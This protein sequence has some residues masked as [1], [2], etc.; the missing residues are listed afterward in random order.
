MTELTI[1]RVFF[2]FLEQYVS[3]VTAVFSAIYIGAFVLSSAIGRLKL[4][5]LDFLVFAVFSAFLAKD[6]VFS[7]NLGATVAAYNKLFLCLIVLKMTTLTD[8]GFRRR[9]LYATFQA[10]LYLLAVFTLF[11]STQT[12][13]YTISWGISVFSLNFT[14]PHL[15][16]AFIVL[17]QALIVFDLNFNQGVHRLFKF[18]LALS[19]IYPL[20]MTGA[21]T[22]AAAGALLFLL[23]LAREVRR[24]NP[25]K[26]SIAIIVLGLTAATWGWALISQAAA[27]TKSE[28][29]S[30]AS[31]S[32]GRE[33][34][35]D[36]YLS[37]AF[38]V[39]PL[40][41]L[42]GLGTGFFGSDEAFFVGSHNDFLY[43]Q[44]AFG[45]VG[46]LL[47]FSYL[48]VRFWNSAAPF[49]SFV[50]LM[51]A[52][53]VAFMNGLSG[54]TDFVIALVVYLVSLTWVPHGVPG[55][56]SPRYIRPNLGIANQGGFDEQPLISTKSSRSN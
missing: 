1:L 40:E 22:F 9:W 54:Y 51:V 4:S 23:P 11:A 24:L 46:I 3:G 2:Q 38:S 31:I 45:A 55:K 19:L 28:L 32:N 47:F 41:F 56:Y 33:T 42:A 18:L 29:I 34:I 21:R 10:F 48:S 50:I 6:L 14:S 16:A 25:V 36:F 44:L 35:W 26:R 52:L 8:F 30:D 20:V 49:I 5:K 39:E 37:K 17:L 13:A 12:W 27:I 7:A 15:T 43:F 53:A